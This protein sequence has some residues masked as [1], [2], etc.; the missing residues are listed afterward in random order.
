MTTILV[1]IDG[2]LALRTGPRPR[3]PFQW[4]RVHEDTPNPAVVEVVQ[5]LATTGL[6]VVYLSG[7][8]DECH[9]A[10]RRWLDKN[11]GVGGA[12]YMRAKGDF[13]GDEIVK[14][15]LYERNVKDRHEVLCV[16]DDRNKVVAMWRG[17]GLTVLQV[18]DGDF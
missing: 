9:G 12:L 8:S 1:D 17:L 3:K 15:E 4:H 18:A 13:R 11:V 7:R 2:T 6:T 10:T 14:R 5:R 16:L